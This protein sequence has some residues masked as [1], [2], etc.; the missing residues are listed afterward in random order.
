MPRQDRSVRRET[1]TVPKAGS[2]TGRITLPFARG[3]LAAAY[4]HRGY[5][6]HTIGRR[7]ELF[8][9][10][11]NPLVYVTVGPDGPV[12]TPAKASKEQIAK[13]V[14]TYL[15]KYHQPGVGGRTRRPAAKV[16][17]R[18]VVKAVVK[19]PSR[20][21]GTVKTDL[22]LR[23]SGSGIWSRCITGGIH[24]T[25]L[26]L[27]YLNK[28]RDYGELRAHFDPKTWNVKTRGLIYTDPGFET[29]LRAALVTMGFSEKAAAAVGYSEQGM[30]GDDYV[31]LDARKPFVYEWLPTYG[32]AESAIDRRN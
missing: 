1:F 22:R 14:A 24:V 19:T 32:V 30:Q 6:I 10:F 8:D 11:S 17:S 13:D 7:L 9:N 31:S 27:A 21:P 20:F 29:S 2:R 28:D 25:R 23:T 15:G 12:V 4:T 16:T 5:T 3:L 26:E 18:A